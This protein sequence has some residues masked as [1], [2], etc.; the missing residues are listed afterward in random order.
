MMSAADGNQWTNQLAGVNRTIYAIDIE[1]AFT[2]PG[3]APVIVNVMAMSSILTT[4]YCQTNFVV[5]HNGP[6]DITV[7]WGA[8]AGCLPPA[9]GKPRA[10]VTVDG[11]W[12]AP[13]AI[14]QS[15]GVEVKTRNSGGVLTD[16]GFVVTVY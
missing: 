11:A 13:I 6:G 2:G 8:V 10:A 12:L 1:I 15:N 3:G 5:T 7:S 16:V 9:R 4:T 14:L